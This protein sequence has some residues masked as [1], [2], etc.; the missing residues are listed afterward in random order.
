MPSRNKQYPP[1]FIVKFINRWRKEEIVEKVRKIKLT[2]ERFG[3]SRDVKV[4]GNE[5]LTPLNQRI[6]VQ[7]KK[8]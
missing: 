8:L 3:G 4:F 5:H 7:G 1:Q 6:L 2:A